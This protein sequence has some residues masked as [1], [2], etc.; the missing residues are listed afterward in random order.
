MSTRLRWY[1]GT[2]CVAGGL[3]LAFLLTRLEL[4]RA[5]EVAGAIAVFA[6]F[7]IVG[8][9]VTLRV[10]DQNRLKEVSITSTFAYGLV[11]L[12]GTAVAVLVFILGSVVAD[13]TRHRGAV[14]TLFNAAQY[15]L[16]LAAG[17]AVY[18]ALGGGY[19]VT[20]ATLPALA[21]GGLAFMVVNW[22]LVSI[23]VSLANDVPVLQGLRRDDLR[24]ELGSSAMVLALAPVAVVVAERSLL[25]LPA[26]VVPLLAVFL[27]SKGEIQAKAQQ[28]AAEEAAE[29]QRRLTRQEHEIVA[30]LQEADRL[31]ADLVAA[32]SHELRN[33]LTTIV[34][35]FG[36]LRVRRQ[37]LSP[38]ERDEL[39]MM[40]IDQS[41]R[42]HRMIEQLLMAARFEQPEGVA[43]L[44]ASRTE[45]DATDLIRQA[46]AE[47]R[48]RHHDRRIAIETNGALPVRVA[49]D[50]VVQVLGNLLDNA[51]KYSPDDEPVRLSGIREGA[52]AVL[53]VEDAGPGIPE[54]ERQR[55]FDRFTQLER[56][57]QRRGGGVGLGLYI[58]RQLARSQDGDL[59]VTDPADG[60]GARFEL[61][62]PLVPDAAT[63]S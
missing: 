6:A 23:V 5:R 25:L 18:H 2:L 28:A 51:C 38:A 7:M 43:S 35:V 15:V 39:V 14:K 50:A 20:T 49:Q 47:A 21:A 3:V 61:H 11:P 56:H 22:L 37:R 33:P 62:L 60:Q 48:A 17:G 27:A 55:I 42:L 29:L 41:E 63:G 1:V 12:A 46:G 9:L 4:D 44:G 57:S 59:L 45:L 34:G 30:R 52:E 31:K 26:L 58:A 32:V 16:A 40:G 19:Q 8:E 13:L 53:V 54:S 36:I 10:N 24:F